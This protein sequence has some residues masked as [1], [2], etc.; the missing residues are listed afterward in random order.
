MYEAY[1]SQ[2]TDAA[3]AQYIA[4]AAY[5]SEL[6]SGKEPDF[7]ESVYSRFSSVYYTNDY[8]S[9]A[10]SVASEAYAS[11][12][13]V[14]AEAASVVSSYFA[15]REATVALD[16]FTEQ[17]N[18]AINEASKSFYGTQPGYYEQATS[19]AA[20]AASSASE[21]VSG[22]VY[23]TQTGYAE[24]ASVSVNAALLAAQ[25]AVSEA[26]YGTTPDVVESASSVVGDSASSISSYVADSASQASE[27]AL[28]VAEAVQARVSAAIYGPEVTQGAI[29]SL[30]SRMSLAVASAQSRI[31]EFGTELSG[32]ASV[33][34]SVISESVES[35]ASS[36]SSAV[37]SIRDEL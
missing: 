27:A 34:A 4:V 14:A 30:N 28:S 18:S 20:D 31:A 8:V 1:A 23:G 19:I 6:V 32:S 21:A 11:A 3:N 9:S 36:V 13:S 15:P 2:I 26:I 5:L 24:A 37:E 33:A 16:R 10:S 29:E 35:A 22:V 7:T 25:V 12:S 17:L